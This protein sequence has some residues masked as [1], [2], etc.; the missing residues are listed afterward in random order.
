MP[1]SSPETDDNYKP[2]KGKR[3]R[4]ETRIEPV[5]LNFGGHSTKKTVIHTKIT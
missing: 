1:N 3:S 5:K 2:T 4:L